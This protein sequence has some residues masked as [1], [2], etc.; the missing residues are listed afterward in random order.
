MYTNGQYLENNRT[1]HVEDSPWKANQIA[2]IIRKNH[3]EPKLIAEVGCGA[4]SILQ[5]LSQKDFLQTSRFLGYDISPQAYK[6]AK[7]RQNDRIRFCYGN[8]FD[9][10]TQD[11][12]ILLVI[13]VFEHVPD[14]MGFLHQCK[15]Q[16]SYKIYHIPLD[17]HVSS[18]IRNSFDQARSQLGHIHYFTAESALS[19]LRDTGHEILDYRYTNS[20]LDLY[21]YHPKLQTAIANIPRWLF[22]KIHLPMTARLLGGY[23]LLVLTS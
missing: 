21:K 19:S 20:A 2:N 1:W 15:A 14:Y 17:I 7:S 9:S 18:V 16:A 22:G 8:I 6:L 11:I 5:E 4:G 23:S 3:I 10:N 12:D 13:D